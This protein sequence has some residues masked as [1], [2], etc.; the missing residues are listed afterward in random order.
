MPDLK[1]PDTKPSL[2]SW[3]K[4]D[5][6]I[7]DEQQEPEKESRSGKLFQL[8]IDPEPSMAEG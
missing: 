3:L 7:M 2:E 4:L 5:D 8:K 1:L 6:K